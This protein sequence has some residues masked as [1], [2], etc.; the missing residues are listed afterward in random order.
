MQDKPL[1]FFL[2][3]NTPTNFFEEAIVSNNYPSLVATKNIEDANFLIL[4]YSWEYY[5]KN[6]LFKQLEDIIS[7][8]EKYNLKLIAITHGDY[9]YTP[10]T[11]Q[12]ITF[13][14]GGYK[15]KNNNNQFLIPS[16]LQDPLKLYYDE[17]LCIRKKQIYP[18]IGF[19]GKANRNLSTFFMDVTKMVIHNLKY[20]LF[21]YK[22]ESQ[23]IIPTP[24]LIRVKAL[25]TIEKS[26]FIISNFVKRQKFFNGL[27]SNYSLEQQHINILEFYENIR[28]SDYTL[29]MRGAGNFSI[30]F[31]Q[32]LAMGRIPVFINTD[33]NLPFDTI[34][35]WREIIPWIEYNELHE[36]PEK[37]ADF[38]KKLSPRDFREKQF[39]MRKIWKTYFT[40]DGFFGNLN[41]LV[42]STLN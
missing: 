39:R 42:T 16:F 36:L 35:P 5:Y 24:N 20:E 23:I 27:P 12:A 19:C 29:C 41:S 17:K 2:I 9:G 8:T 15:T 30:R 26:S 3:E 13:R 37:I 11:S 14:S 1:V 4:P 6:K 33:C 10:Y 38:H 28:N 34:I 22:E 18:S 40:K 32:V 7:T 25:K 31:C 21:V